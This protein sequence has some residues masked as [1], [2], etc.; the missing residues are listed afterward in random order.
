[1]AAGKNLG[2]D[3][4]ILKAILF[5]APY[6]GTERVLVKVGLKVDSASIKSFEGQT[7][8]LNILQKDKG[9]IFAIDESRNRSLKVSL[10]VSLKDYFA[11]EPEVVVFARY[12][13]TSAYK[14]FRL[15][16]F[17]GLKKLIHPQ[18]DPAAA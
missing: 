8:Q 11:A 13:K 5:H 6:E 7:L 18:R 10:A 9:I 16:W 3:P 1:M 2:D 15:Q 4:C 14:H 17:I 12:D